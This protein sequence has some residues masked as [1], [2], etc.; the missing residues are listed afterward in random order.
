[1]Q[2]PQADPVMRYF[3]FFFIVMWAFLS[4]LIAHIGGWSQLSEYY[5]TDQPFSG[6]IRRWQSGS[7][8]WGTNYGNCLNIGANSEGLYLSVMFLFRTGHPPLFIPWEDISVE[9]RTTWGIF[10]TI[11]L[12]FSKAP[13]HTT[14]YQP[15]VRRQDKDRGRRKMAE[16]I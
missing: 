5:R 9:E 1:M 6:K 2:S 8:R 14:G 11:R 10:R 12:T 4:V 3:P 13:R 7:M 16:P 15:E